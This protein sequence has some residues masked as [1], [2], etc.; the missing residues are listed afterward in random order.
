MVWHPNLFFF[1]FDF[2][3]LVLWCM[4]AYYV[5]YIVFELNAGC[6]RAQIFSK[7]DFIAEKHGILAGYYLVTA[8]QDSCLF[9]RFVEIDCF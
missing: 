3:L 4:Y 6:F 8:V 9:G 1:H 5:F 2:Y 7:P